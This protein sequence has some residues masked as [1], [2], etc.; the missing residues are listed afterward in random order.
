MQFHSFRKYKIILYLQ[1]NSTECR[2]LK[3]KQTHRNTQA[4][5]FHC[6][7]T[8]RRKFLFLYEF[9]SIVLLL[10]QSIL[11]RS[12]VGHWS[13]RGLC[14]ARSARLSECRVTAGRLQPS[15]NASIN[16]GQAYRRGGCV[17]CR[18]NATSPLDVGFFV[19]LCVRVLLQNILLGDRVWTLAR[20]VFPAGCAE[21]HWAAELTQDATAAIVRESRY[22]R[23]R[24]LTSR[25]VDSSFQASSR[26]LSIIFIFGSINIQNYYTIRT[27]NH[28]FI[29][30]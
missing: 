25:E 17:R 11:C 21:R 15:H 14:R 28:T 27:I 23:R 6:H 19:D 30:K 4:D 22:A 20:A 9:S 2:Y 26:S 8:S 5:R 10:Q 18:L 7:R 13:E 1:K 3:T 16:R 29:Q 12:R 24:E